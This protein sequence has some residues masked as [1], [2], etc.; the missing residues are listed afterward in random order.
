[1]VEKSTIKWTKTHCGK[2]DHGGC[3]L[4]VGVEDNAVVRVK[5]D[6]DGFLNRGYICPKAVAS[7]V[8]KGRKT[9][10]GQMAADLVA[11]SD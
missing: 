7:P 2:M 6:P 8:A 3:A 9:R 11:G 5:G 1:M 10:R 4:L